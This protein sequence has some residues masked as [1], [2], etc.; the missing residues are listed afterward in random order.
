[1]GTQNPPVPVTG[2]L[3]VLFPFGLFSVGPV[4]EDL[5]VHQLGGV[6]VEPYPTGVGET[7]DP[8]G[9]GTFRLKDPGSYPESPTFSGFTVVKSITCSGLGIGERGAVFREKLGRAFDALEQFS[10]EEEFMYGLTKGGPDDNPFLA[11]SN[12]VTPFG[13]TGFAALEA[14]ARLEDIIAATGHTGVIHT[15][16]SVV[17]YWRSLQAVEKSGGRLVTPNG[18]SVVSGAGYLNTDRTTGAPYGMTPPDEDEAWA[19]A[20][21]DVQVRRGQ[22]IITPDN[23]REA[24]DRDTNT[25]TFYAE[26]NYVVDWTTELQTAVKVD[27]VS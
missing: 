18:N 22:R 7:H 4:L 26:R 24:L 27:R 5:D 21:G 15:V 19:Y 2:P 3:P 17:T 12:V 25:S 8:C 1:M 23:D 16:P 9:T 11:D 10:V 14:L 20:T 13:A 6:A